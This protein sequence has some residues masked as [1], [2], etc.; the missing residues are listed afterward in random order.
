MLEIWGRLL[1]QVPGSGLLLKSALFTTASGQERVRRSF[2][3]QDIDASR[4][5][6]CGPQP[7]HASH[8]ALH[9]RIDIALDTFPY[10]GTATT[11]DALWMGVPVITLA[12]QTHASRVGRS[13]LS[14]IGLPQLVAFTPDQ[15]V[16]IATDLAKD[17]AGIDSL[18]RSMRARMLASP[19]MDAPGFARNVE[20]AYR[21]M[22]RKWC[23]T[24]AGTTD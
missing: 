7:D 14:N 5:N 13:L 11:C 9:G 21:Q 4:L 8:L 23:A 10:H 1:R 22:W 3:A 24:A 15:Y 17:P 12:G 18:R 6:L 20:A 19:L 16:Q 2:A